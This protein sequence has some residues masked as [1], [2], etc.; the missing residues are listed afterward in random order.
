MD[1]SVRQWSPAWPASMVPA[2]TSRIVGYSTC[3]APPM[4]RVVYRAPS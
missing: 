4:A 2:P 1:K 3:R